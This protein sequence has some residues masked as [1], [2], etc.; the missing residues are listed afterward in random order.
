MNILREFEEKNAFVK[1]QTKK[2][3]LRNVNQIFN[4][5]TKAK[6]W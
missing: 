4:S 1:L 2:K 5:I 3:T 6:R